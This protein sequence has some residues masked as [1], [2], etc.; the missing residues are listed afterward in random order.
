[1][2]AFAQAELSEDVY[3]QRPRGFPRIDGRDTVFKLNKSLY[4]LK[5]APKSFYDKLRMGLEQRGFTRSE[6]DHCLFLKK[7]MMVVVYV[8]MT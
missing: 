7:G 8:V 1:M 2:N 5:Q 4:G 6:V 3:I